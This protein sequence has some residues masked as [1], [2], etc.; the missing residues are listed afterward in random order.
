MRKRI[1]TSISQICALMPMHINAVTEN[2]FI[3]KLTLFAIAFQFHKAI[4]N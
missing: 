2:G 4:L 3:I 1:E